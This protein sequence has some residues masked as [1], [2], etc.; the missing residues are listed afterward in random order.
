M[1]KF[2][3]SGTQLPSLQLY[4][5]GVSQRHPSTTYPSRY[6]TQPPQPQ[7]VHKYNDTLPTVSPSVG[8]GPG[9]VPVRQPLSAE[10]NNN[11]NSS[12]YN[13]TNHSQSPPTY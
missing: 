4:S 3:E 1:S 6:T 9:P 8:P 7:D 13:V 5:I 2:G 11:N 10:G 12:Y